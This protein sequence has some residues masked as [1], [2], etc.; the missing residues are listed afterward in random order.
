M[1]FFVPVVVFFVLNTVNVL[2]A[3][4]V[5]DILFHEKRTDFIPN[6]PHELLRVHS[7]VDTDQI[8]AYLCH[9]DPQCRTFVSDSSTCRLY[10]GVRET[11]QI[12]TASSTS[13][14]VGEIL[15]DDID[16]SS[17]Y[18]KSCN[19]CYPDR[20]LICKDNRCQ[21]PANTYW[22]GQ[23]KCIN[24]QFINPSSTCK[25]NDWC[26]EDMNMSCVC[27][28]CKCPP[29]TFWSNQTCVPQHTAGVPCNSSEECRNDLN[30][31]CS[32]V[33]KTCTS[34]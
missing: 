1:I 19:R 4:M 27:N 3:D 8:C 16:L 18:N 29:T 23:N 31:V 9:Q 20:Y 22:N 17:S 5:S 30:V 11:G 24:Q 25:N 2:H 21:C 13:S 7:A 6:N 33:N 28:K 10:E 34:K 32:R 12:I 26:R 14:I 15:Y